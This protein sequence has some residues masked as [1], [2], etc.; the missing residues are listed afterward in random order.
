MCE[1]KLSRAGL[2]KGLESCLRLRT[3]VLAV[4]IIKREDEIPQGASRPLRDLGN[5][6]AL[7]QALSEARRRGK[8]LALLKEDNWCFEPVVGLGFAPPPR[9]FMDGQNRFPGT[10]KSAEAGSRWA[11]QMPRLKA[12]EYIGVV[13]S[14]LEKEDLD[15]DLLIIYCDPAQL[16][17]ILMAVNWIDGNDVTSVLSGHAACVYAI[18]PAFKN[19]TFSVAIPCIGDR[20]RAAAQENELI[21]AV[22][23]E[24]TGDLMEGLNALE[25]DAPLFPI[26]YDL[27]F[28]YPLED[29]YIRLGKKVGLDIK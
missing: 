29:S 6:M 9:E 7:C 1:R 5:H 13:V 21:F 25:A 19:R 8:T 12:G 24:K 23:W 18:V 11:R 16:T 4:K 26:G 20:K 15:P 17:N 2:A 14:P 10:A 28:E 27:E 3:K 22:P